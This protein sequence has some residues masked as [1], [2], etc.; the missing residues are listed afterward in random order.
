ME[1]LRCLKRRLS[2]VVYRQMRADAGE[3][4]EAV[5]A[6]GPGGHSVASTSSSAAGS[7]PDTGTSE[8]SLPGPTTPDASPTTPRRET[9]ALT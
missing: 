4:C 7:H 9:A 1:A 5:V 3:P 6:A 8:E 2:D